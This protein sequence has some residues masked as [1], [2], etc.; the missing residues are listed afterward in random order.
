VLFLVN[1]AS[2]FSYDDS[3]LM[4]INDHFLAF[5]ILLTSLRYVFLGNYFEIDPRQID[6]VA[7]SFPLLCR[8]NRRIVSEM[9]VLRLLVN[10]LSSAIVH[11]ALIFCTSV[12][13][14][15]NCE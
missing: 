11:G 7:N 10:C 15:I 5:I 8:S 3:G 12:Y 2:S 4:L 6:C 1:L 14:S 9:T 13:T